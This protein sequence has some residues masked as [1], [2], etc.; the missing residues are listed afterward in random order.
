PVSFYATTDAA[1]GCITSYGWTY[2]SSWSFV[3]QSDN[4]I[5][6]QP[7]GTPDDSNPIKATV[8]FSC[9]SSITSGNYVPPYATPVL[10]GSNLI[11][12]SASFVLQNASSASVTWTS[13]DMN[14]ATVNSS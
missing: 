5:T 7:S 11:C 12:S 14:I 13:S 2:P 8:N 4:S 6:L 3:S 9:G 10:T 1:L